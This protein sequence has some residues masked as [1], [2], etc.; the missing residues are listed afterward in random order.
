MFD[1]HLDQYS[2]VLRCTGGLVVLDEFPD[3]L[4]AHSRCKVQGVSSGD[5]CRA[6]VYCT[7]DIFVELFH[8]FVPAS[9]FAS[10]Q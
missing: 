5:Y 2:I 3:F 6:G 8:V 4:Y 1:P 9:P 10:R 7:L